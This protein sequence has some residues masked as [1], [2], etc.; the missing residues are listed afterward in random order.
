[1][2]PNPAYKGEWKPKQIP[3]PEYFVDEKPSDFT[4]IVILLIGCG[5]I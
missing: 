2:I 4:P 3:N 1:M 5:W